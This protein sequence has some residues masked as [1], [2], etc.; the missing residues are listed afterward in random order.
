MRN[1]SKDKDEQPPVPRRPRLPAL[2]KDAAD[3]DAFQALVAYAYLQA[4]NQRKQAVEELKQDAD[5]IS[6]VI[7][8]QH[9]VAVSDFDLQGKL[10]Y[11]IEQ[12]RKITNAGGAVIALAEGDDQI[13]CRSRAG[14]IGPPL[15]ARLDPY[16]GISGECIRTGELLYCDDTETDSRVNLSACRQ[17]GIRSILALPLILHEQTLGVVEIFSGWAGV[18]GDRESRTMKMLAG[19]IIEALWE[20]ETPIV[21]A[22]GG[23]AA[24]SAQAEQ[25]RAVAAQP[26]HEAL[27]AA[28]AEVAARAE[29][30]VAWPDVLNPIVAEP[31]VVSPVAPNA[32]EF[33]FLKR[34][35]EP[36]LFTPKVIIAL[37]LVLMLLAILIW[38][39]WRPRPLPLPSEQTSL[40]ADDSEPQPTIA[41]V[42]AGEAHLSEIR[43]W[44]KTDY[45]SIAVFLDGAAKYQAAALHDPER[46]YFDL[47]DTSLPAEFEKKREMVV[48][49]NDR[50]VERVRAAQKDG[51]VTRVVLDLKGP[52][53]YNT[54]LSSESPYRL[55]IAVH[56]RGTKAVLMDLPSPVAEPSGAE[57]TEAESATPANAA[58]A[59]EMR[60]V[61][62][63]AAGAKHRLRIVIDPG[64]G[65]SENGAIG[66]NGLKEKDL[67]LDVAHRLGTLLAMKLGADIFYTRTDDRSV[68][69]EERTQYA[70]QLQADMFISVHAN[71]SLD[72]NAR[73]IE[74]YYMDSA[75]S[76]HEAEVAARE[77]A[78]SKTKVGSALPAHLAMRDKIERSHKLAN[79]VQQA[80]YDS[81]ADGQLRNRGVKKAPFVVLLGADM[82]AVLA[83]ISFLSSPDDERVLGNPDLRDRVADA[84]YRGI[85]KYLAGSKQEKP[86]IRSAALAGK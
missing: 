65:G 67:V 86:Y 59:A 19:Q 36:T 3:K 40:H 4:Q 83:E 62:P 69:L 60:F 5:A 77:N 30:N 8:T 46:I 6:A 66:R 12:A 33:D 61:P 27:A 28:E 53:E 48:D 42:A 16:S 47:Q 11:I 10:D 44:S 75:S 51:N 70:N 29:K 18:F 76:M 58:L 74:T 72:P 64:H 32:V 52:A 21:N 85:A 17:L 78:S 63:A 49:V 71:S 14:L 43:H 35:T 7:E 15:G 38:Q 23:A 57:R 41:P 31:A 80:L 1:H 2:A 45:T 26:M 73:G 34:E 79:M 81:L 50:L 22:S 68:S 24:A 37:I 55:M 84:L 39:H 56:P 82:P 20:E 54:V 9:A 13:V 25:S